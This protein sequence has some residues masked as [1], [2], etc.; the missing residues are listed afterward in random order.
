MHI[1]NRIKDVLKQQRRSAA[2]LAAEIFVTRTHIYKILSKESI[3]S[4]LLMRISKA[5]GHDFFA[6][7]SRNLDS[8]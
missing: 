6:D 7:L 3:D 1:G 4:Q 2:W 5:L 8:K